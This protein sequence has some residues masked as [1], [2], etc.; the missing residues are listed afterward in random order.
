[1]TL[2]FQATEEGRYDN[3]RISKE[4]LSRKDATKW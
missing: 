1:M 4:T 3:S 2:N